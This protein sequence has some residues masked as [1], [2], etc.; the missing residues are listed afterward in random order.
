[1]DLNNDKR[2][3]DFLHPAGQKSTGMKVPEGYFDSL[4]HKIL[5][6]VHDEK[7]ERKIVPITRKVYGVVA[8]FAVAASLIWGAFF[9]FSPKG[10][11]TNLNNDVA[12][13][14]NWELYEEMDE[15]FLAENLTEADLEN[16]EFENTYLSSE[17]I[18]NYI[19]ENHYSEYLISELY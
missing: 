6:K 10:V 8:I 3:F 13:T 5:S 1:M 17:E 4:E 7:T 12:E 2:N 9:F 16:I 18:L 19:E 15:Y 11:D 14:L